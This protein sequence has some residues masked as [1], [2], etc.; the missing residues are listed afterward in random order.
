MNK[1][2]KTLVKFENYFE[3][4]PQIFKT[5]C[6]N[7]KT[8]PHFPHFLSGK[9]TGPRAFFDLLYVLQGFGVFFCCKTQAIALCM[10]L[11]VFGNNAKT[12]FVI[13]SNIKEIKSSQSWPC[14]V[15]KSIGTIL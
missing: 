14:L 5:N 9:W 11:I 10:W 13:F 2:K 7:C 12:L 6:R 4:K 3:I 15:S 8:A 1:L